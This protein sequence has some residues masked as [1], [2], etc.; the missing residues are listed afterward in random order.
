MV[1]FERYKLKNG[2][3]VLLHQDKTTPMVVVNTLYDVGARDENENK[4]GFAH[5][6]EHLMFGGSIHIQEFDKALQKAGGES[7]AFTSNDITNYYDIVPAQNIETALWLESD[8]MLSL[9]FT[10]KSLEV[11]RNVVIEEF[12]QRYLNQPYGDV[13]LELRPLAYEKHPYKWATIGKDISH[14]ENATMEDVKAFFNKYYC[15][16]N[17]ILC[18]SGNIDDSTIRENIEK[19]FGSIQG[20]S[21]PL[22]KTPKEPKQESFKIKIIERD[23][24]ANAF[25]YAFKMCSRK[26][27]GYYLG[28]MMSDAIGKDSSSILNIT[29]KKELELVTEI[30]AFITGSLDDGLF[31]ISGKLAEGIDFEEL[32][33]QLW[34]KLEEVKNN[35]VSAKK[36][37]ALKNKISTAKAFQE[38][39]LLNRSINLSFFELLGDANAINEEGLIYQKISHS[40]LVLFAN[41]LFSKNNCSLLKVSKNAG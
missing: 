27:T 37:E 34:L 41:E 5:L 2:L 21:K 32:D 3:T 15:P 26:S 11:Q 38:Q 22:R 36:L 6:F 4:T 12:K 31:I 20:G 7:N 40:D 24:P 17:A 28:D 29:L 30:N 33:E 19:Y 39:G 23:V 13:W 1:S 14:I 8:R 16:A 25:Y 9:A 18:I 10:D 35:G